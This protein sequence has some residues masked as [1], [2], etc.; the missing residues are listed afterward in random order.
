MLLIY[1]TLVSFLEILTD[2][3]MNSWEISLWRKEKD[4]FQPTNQVESYKLVTS[5]AHFVE[6]L[7]NNFRQ[8]HSDG[9]HHSVF[10]L[11]EILIPMPSWCR[12]EHT[13]LW[14]SWPITSKV[15]NDYFICFLKYA[16]LLLI[17]NHDRYYPDYSSALSAST[18]LP[19]PTVLEE[20]KEV[21]YSTI[22]LQVD[23]EHSMSKAVSLSWMSPPTEQSPQNS[24]DWLQRTL[25]QAGNLWFSKTEVSVWCPEDI[26]WWKVFSDEPG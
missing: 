12:E 21:S 24:V 17:I 10:K 1:Q 16:S 18:Y 25:T 4:F 9:R 7:C 20:H 5:T 8:G 15:L 2:I 19:F 14:M 11:L 26:F 3:P 6:T 23:C 22:I 13:M